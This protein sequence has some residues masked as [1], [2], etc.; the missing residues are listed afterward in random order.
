MFWEIKQMSLKNKFK[1]SSVALASAMAM[2]AMTVPSIAS[3]EVGYNAAVSSMYLWRGQ[4]VSNGAV[5]SG[6]IDYSH[7]SGVYVSGW[8]ST[9]IVGDTITADSDSGNGYEFD[10]ILGYSGEVAGVGYDISYWEIDYPQT[11]TEAFNEAS[12][13]LS[14]ADFSFS[15]TTNT[16]SAVDY[17]Y[18]TV[19]YSYDKFGITYGMSDAGAGAEYTHVDLSYAATDALSFTL[20]K[21]SDD[22][23]GVAEE[24]LIA[25]SYSLPIGK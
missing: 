23:A 16:D 10:I 12:L 9:G 22:G 6:G 13:G 5:V 8:A 1:L 7:D 25:V 21:A 19:G 20:S 24:M 3:A 18:M 2:G 15:Y 14:Y 11:Y 17:D 4:D